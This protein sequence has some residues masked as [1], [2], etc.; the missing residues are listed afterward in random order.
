MTTLKSIRI[1]CKHIFPDFISGK[2]CHVEIHIMA[3]KHFDKVVQ[4]VFITKRKEEGTWDD[5]RRD[6]GTNSTLRIKEQEK[7]LTL[8]KHDDDDDDDELTN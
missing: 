1:F 2:I 3:N 5:R 4:L 7:R 8:N 6:G